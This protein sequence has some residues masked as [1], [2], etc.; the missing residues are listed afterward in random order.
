M[1]PELYSQH[2]DTVA[3]RWQAAL[4]FAGFEAAIIAAGRPRHYFLDDRAAP[5]QPNPH[6]AQWFPDGDCADAMLLIRPGHRPRLFFHQPRDYWHQPPRLPA[7]ADAN[8]DAAVFAEADDLRNAVAAAMRDCNRPACVGEE[9]PG[10]LGAA[11]HNP[12]LLLSH[13]H[14]HRAAKTPFEIDCMARAN[15]RAA[16]G[17]VAARAA[18][19]AG[20]SEFD[21]HMRYLAA[22]RQTPEELPYHSIVAQ[23]GHAG[24]L[25]Y[26]HYD[27]EPPQPLLSFLIDA[28][29]S[30]CGYAAD[31]TRTY[32]ADADGDFAALVHDLDAA[33]QR[34]IGDIRPGM[35]FADLHAAAHRVVAELL[36]A[37]G[38]VR[39]T[40]QA[41]LD[42][43]ITRAFLPHGLGHL[44]GLQV[45][46]VG[47][48]QAS[49]EGGL[50]PP[51]PAYPALRL[52]RTI[53]MDHVFTIEP[54]LYFIPM[55]LDE[56]RAGSAA[57]EVDWN[58]IEHFTPFGG[59]R[60]EDNVVVTADGVRNL[61]REA[62]TRHA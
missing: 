61:T 6:F 46:D 11:E 24:V 7:W 21:T 12:A 41:A 33:Q 52:T 40:P 44:I 3:Q 19:E 18:F 5:F 47:G 51:D 36:A 23:N 29:A 16:A 62:F 38:I 10:N 8:L 13:L 54:G 14:Y 57:G 37:H 50:R 25:H 20:E 17:H 22:A 42:G 30:E 32:A 28:G 1:N 27:R 49:P 45:H 9:P 34:L 43:G 31:V 59:I 2:L 58:R 35:D 15:D 26:Q 48:Q 4:E 39:C 55:L 53:E 60:I 56:L